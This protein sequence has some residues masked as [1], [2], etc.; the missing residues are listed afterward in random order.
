MSL[1]VIVLTIFFICDII[2]VIYV[3]TNKKERKN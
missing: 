1:E 2:L 3:I